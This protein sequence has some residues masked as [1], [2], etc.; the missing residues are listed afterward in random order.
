[1]KT[2][3]LCT[4][5]LLLAVCVFAPPAFADV[6]SSQ[7][8]QT[9]YYEKGKISIEVHENEMK[10]TVPQSSE[11]SYIIVTF[12]DSQGNAP[13]AARPA[14]VSEGTVIYEIAD[15]R[16][17]V[18]YIQL[19]RNEN[20]QGT[21]TG[22]IGGMESIAVLMENVSAKIIPSLVYDSS[23]KKFSAQAVSADALCYYL[24]PSSNV[25]SSD[26]DIVKQALAVTEGKTAAYDK[27]VAVHDW[28]A[29][30][31]YYD[32][33]ALKAGSGWPVDASRTLKT[34]RT[35]CEGYANLATAMLRANGIP[36]KTI[37]GYALYDDE[38]S[39]NLSNM[40][41]DRAN[42]AWTEAFVNGRWILMD[43][44]WDSDNI[45]ENGEYQ[46]AEALHTYFDSTLEFFSYTHRQS[47]NDE[48][49]SSAMKIEFSD[50][51]G[52][53]ALEPIRFAVNNDLMNGVGESRFSPDSETTQAMFLTV[54]ARLSGDEL[55][56]TDEGGQ[57]A[58]SSQEEKE[59][60]SSAVAWAREK[61]I[62]EGID[63]MFDPDAQI[64]RQMMA[65]MLRN[66]I[67]YAEPELAAGLETESTDSATDTTQT[68]QAFQ[69]PFS[70]PEG[71]QEGDRSDG[72]ESISF[73]DQSDI[74]S[75]A[76]EAVLATV[77]LGFLKGY[78]DGSFGP[79]NTL[80]RAEMAAVIER[81][82]YKKL[83]QILG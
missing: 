80:T 49:N 52:H 55:T 7:T 82:K 37:I 6:F 67:N 58:Q 15:R 54:L 19:Y 45:Y 46:T 28:V 30:N 44:T 11:F 69:Q 9:S 65:V 8:I 76:S 3:A 73:T 42:H 43:V 62:L 38:D 32:Y 14:K 59:W 81:L 21:F 53:W 35:V 26:P 56:D 72:S 31:I 61:G 27:L 2:A 12:M 48:Y 23:V 17:G 18:Y 36:A 51:A 39:W 83:M 57:T 33:D 4:A 50:V 63:A 20:A 64:N 29:S 40:Y 68:S 60:Y 78:D 5:V 22:V 79:E 70:V 77:R 66:Y 34:K 24:K 1:M 47:Y 16:D 25:Q 75:W 74:A 71:E 41:G 13:H 10:V